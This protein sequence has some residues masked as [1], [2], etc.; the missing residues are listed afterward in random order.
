MTSSVSDTE[1]EPIAPTKGPNPISVIGLAGTVVPADATIRRALANATLILS[2]S[3]HRKAA[4]AV[5]NPAARHVEIEDGLDAAMDT[6][7]AHQGPAVVLAS[8]D[9]GFFGIGRILAERLGPHRLTVYPAPSAVSMAFARL[10]LPWDDAVVVSAHGRPLVQAAQAVAKSAKAA[11]LTSPDSPPQ[12]L[13]R[14]LIA[15]GVDRRWVA[16]CSGLGAVEETVER[17][18]LDALAAG[19]WDPLSVV[20]IVDQEH[21]AST[22]PT[23]A[24]GLPRNRFAYRDGMI[25]KDEVRAV[26]LGKLALPMTGVVWDVGAG[27]GSVAI[28]CARLVPELR[29]IAIERDPESAVRIRANAARF[30]VSI[31]VLGGDAPAVLADLPDPDRAFVGGGGTVVLDAALARL[32]PGGTIVATFAAINRAAAAFDR[33]GHLSEIAVNHGCLL[34]DGGVRMVADNPVFVAWGTSAGSGLSDPIGTPSGG[35]A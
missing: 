7:D 10:G 22:Q 35:L 5:T 13:G 26:V 17:I 11:V 28:E 16:V 15:L 20:I 12:A 9:P 2:G 29:V 32:R 23:L 30:G 1:H 33:L 31:E 25:T 14:E 6:L 3:R 18:D 27:S 34:P 4:A 21:P 19:T 8:G 24:W